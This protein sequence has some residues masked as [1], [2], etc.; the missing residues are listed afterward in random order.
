MD[1]ENPLAS[2]PFFTEP[3]FDRERFA[4]ENDLE[5]RLSALNEPIPEPM[6]DKEVWKDVG[7]SALTGVAKG[8]AGVGIGGVGSIGSTISDVLNLG[9]GAGAY[10][11]EKLDIISPEEKARMMSEP[12]ISGQTPE[13]LAGRRDP[14]TG[15]P[16][17]KGVVETFKPTMKA[18]GADI[19]AYEP[20]STQ[21]KVA[22]SAAEFAAQGLPG[23]L[24]TMPG[25]VTTGAGAGAGSEFAALS[26]QSPD[27]EAYNRVIGA[28]GGAGA[29]A[30]ASSVAGSIV[31]A[32]KALAMP[33]RVG[34]QGLAEAY[35]A[36]LRRGQAQMT[37]E[38]VAA[39]QARGVEISFADMGGPEVRKILGKAAESTTENT[40]IAAAHNAFV[41]QRAVE[42]GQRL[43][44]DI[45][46][47]FGGNLDAA[48][49]Q[50]LQEESGKLIRDQVYTATRATPQAQAIDQSAFASLLDR[51]TFRDAMRRADKTAEDAPNFGIRPPEVIA[52]VEGTEQRFM[53][54]PRG[55]VEVPAT[56]AVPERV[57][58]GNLSYWDQV[59][60]ELRSMSEMELRRGDNT[61]AA[62]ID[63]MR[64]DLLKTLDNVPGYTNARGVAFETFQ[65][66]SAPEAGYKFF[67][68]MNA[69]KRRDL[70]QAFDRMNPDQRE[71][72]AAGFAAK[73]SE[74]AANGDVGG[75]AKKFTK[76]NNFRERALAVLGPERY[77]RIQGSVLSEDILSKAKEL[78]FIRE[79]RSI[80]PAGVTGAASAAGIDMLMSGSNAMTPEMVMKMAIGA[81]VGAAGKTVLSATERR[82]ASNILPLAVSSR[83]E[84]VAR[85]GMLASRSPVVGDVLNKFST[86]LSNT[87]SAAKNPNME[88]EARATGGAVNLMALSKSAKRHVTQST[89]ALLNESDDNVAHALEIAN[90]HI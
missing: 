58:P 90:K 65:A 57:V 50:A 84:D 82:I 73:I 27:E 59:Q 40:E 88:R 74:A 19:V 56:Q 35:A 14:I 66:A 79:S 28:L 17:Y 12:V 86:A 45:A 78:N 52:G 49:L 25:R 10:L 37:P 89:E 4:R 68:N 20:Q 53:Q 9:K 29:G 64:K 2:H 38:Q 42:S 36:D 13:E 31:R 69:F 60:R 16:T 21:G 55:I 63:A 44:G 24:R 26:S 6:S 7:K 77:A 1:E 51:P 75:L 18:A 5:G 3:L 80:A 87:I 46:G 54:T 70:Q 85:L 41:R 67:S 71:L 15:L 62:T 76:D 30:A 43:S 8:A 23:A 72:F 83:P 34:A 81:A 47:E 11:G 32:A 33:E 61:A 39:A 48:G 22:E